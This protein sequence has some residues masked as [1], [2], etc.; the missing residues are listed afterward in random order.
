M[1]ITLSA[2]LQADIPTSR[3]SCTES[4]FSQVAVCLWLHHSP[5]PWQR[6]DGSYWRQ[7]FYSIP[8]SILL[9]PHPLVFFINKALQRAALP[10]LNYFS[11]NLAPALVKFKICTVTAPPLPCSH[12]QSSVAQPVLKLVIL[13]QSL[14]CQYYTFALPSVSF[15]FPSCIQRIR[16]LFSSGAR[17]L[18]WLLVHFCLTYL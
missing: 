13:H 7:I 6:S 11:L 10:F 8:T 18:L 17:K 9:R 3:C 5:Q 14:Q 1:P 16:V 2:P 15:M 12:S 4:F